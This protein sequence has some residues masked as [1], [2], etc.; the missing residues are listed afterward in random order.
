M[1]VYLIFNNLEFDARLKPALF[2]GQLEMFLMDFLSIFLF[3]VQQ[4]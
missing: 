1:R 4:N 2:V 3:H